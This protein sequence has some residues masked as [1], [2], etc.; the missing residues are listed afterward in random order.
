MA[1]GV[2]FL[3]SFF[4]HSHSLG[5]QYFFCAILLAADDPTRLQNVQKDIYITIAEKHHVSCANVE[6][7]IRTIRD[8]LMRHRNSELFSLL[9][10]QTLWSQSL[11]YPR[12]CIAVFASYLTGFTV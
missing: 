2:F 11:P 5:Y 1:M 3:H 10:V 4:L 7:N 9:G 8:V 12:E 6:R